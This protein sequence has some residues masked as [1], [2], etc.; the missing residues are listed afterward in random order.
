MYKVLIAAVLVGIIF[1][2]WNCVSWTMLSW[3]H[4]TIRHLQSEKQILDSLVANT[5]GKGGIYIA[6]EIPISVTHPEEL[7]ERTP[8]GSSA[9]ISFQPDTLNQNMKY[10]MIY[11]LV[12]SIVISTLIVF[13]L[14]CTSELSYFS[15][16]FFVV[17]IGLVGALIG[18]IPNW[19]WWGFDLSYTIVM[20]ADVLIGWFLAG[21]VIA[22]LAGRDSEYGL[23][24]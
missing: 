11:A 21:L 13:L 10:R 1:F 23:K 7:Q 22:A 14:S 18:H 15:R 2:A 6:P 24:D 3:H 5:G 16:V 20:T 19:I 17:M 8:G 4:Q 9:F 12:N